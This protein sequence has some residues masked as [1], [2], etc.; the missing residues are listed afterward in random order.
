M[1]EHIVARFTSDEAVAL[2]L[3]EALTVPRQRFT[4]FRPAGRSERPT[5]RKPG[6]QQNVPGM[7]VPT[8]WGAKPA[9][10]HRPAFSRREDVRTG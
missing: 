10:P 4:P 3:V 9:P 7:A 6:G 1:H 2:L 5:A 8:L